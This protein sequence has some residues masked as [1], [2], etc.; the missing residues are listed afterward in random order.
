MI[1]FLQLK[2]R[3]GVGVTRQPHKLKIGGAIPSPATI[4][5]VVKWSSGQAVQ[6]ENLKLET[7]PT[8][9]WLREAAGIA[10]LALGFLALIVLT[11]CTPV[12]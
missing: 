6:S 4:Q 2:L 7:Y 1:T 3:G 8:A 10:V 9:T 11:G 5:K 12:H